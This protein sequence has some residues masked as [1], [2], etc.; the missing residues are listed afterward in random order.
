MNPAAPGM[1][2]DRNAHNP[3]GAMPSARSPDF[4]GWRSNGLVCR[5]VLLLFSFS[6]S[7]L[8]F[9]VADPV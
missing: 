1:A 3:I 9:L 6:G 5:I 7:G 8:L 2:D 4:A